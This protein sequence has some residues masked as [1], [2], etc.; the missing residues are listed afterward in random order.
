MD[1]IKEKII[2]F[3]KRI[4]NEKVIIQRKFE[5][6]SKDMNLDILIE[7]VDKKLTI[8]I[9]ERFKEAW[10]VKLRGLDKKTRA[11]E[12]SITQL[13][14][15]TENLALAIANIEKKS[16]EMILSPAVAQQTYNMNWLSWGNKVEK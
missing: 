1:M 12:K 16:H 8:D 10:E 9:F 6:L 14:S 4:D 11:S 2:I 7:R 13:E 3:E 15:F 5:K